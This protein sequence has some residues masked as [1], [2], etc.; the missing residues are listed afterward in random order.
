MECR[1][2]RSGIGAPSPGGDRKVSLATKVLIGVALGILTGLFFG[3]KVAFLKLPGDAFIQLLQMTV[4]P[5]VM[6]SLIVGLGRLSYQQAAALA[7]KCG[8]ILML[9]WGMGLM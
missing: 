1:P 9:L 6:T 8:L 7:R 5:Y 4:L 3:E 2:T